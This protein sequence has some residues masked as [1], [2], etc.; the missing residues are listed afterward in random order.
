MLACN[1]NG[2]MGKL[3]SEKDGIEVWMVKERDRQA[4]WIGI[5][6]RTTQSQTRM[7]TKEE[8]G[9]NMD[10]NYRFLNIWEN[11]KSVNVDK[12]IEI[13]GNGVVFIRYE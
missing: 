2:V 10:E 5:F 3:I 8:L 9:L 12:I 6:N 7:F 11:R 13:S 4:G 1:Q